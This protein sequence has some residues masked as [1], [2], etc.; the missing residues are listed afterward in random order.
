MTAS[1]RAGRPG[2]TATRATS[3]TR[4]GR[5]AEVG[6]DHV[7]AGHE[8]LLPLRR[9]PAVRGVLRGGDR[10][11]RHYLRPD[12]RQGQAGAQYFG[13]YGTGDATLS[14]IT[15]R[16]PTR[17]DSR[18]RVRDQRRSDHPLSSSDAPRWASR[19]PRTSLHGLRIGS[20]CSAS[21]A[22]SSSICST[23]AR[24]SIRTNEARARSSSVLAPPRS[25]K[26]RSARASSIL[27]SA[28]VDR[29]L[30]LLHQA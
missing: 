3:T 2:A 30:L 29:E 8:G 26:A 17:P 25:P 4:S 20:V 13:F 15:S 12:R 28:D 10:A 11:G 5:G 6:D 9:A 23:I 21:S 16:P 22:S 18:W 27:V 24:A 14:T 19:P 7:A 1:V